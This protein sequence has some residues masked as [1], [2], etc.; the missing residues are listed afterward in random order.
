MFKNKILFFQIRKYSDFKIFK[1]SKM[2][3]IW[4]CSKFEKYSKFEKVH[5]QKLFKIRKYSDFTSKNL[6]KNNYK[7]VHL[8]RKENI[9][10]IE[11][12]K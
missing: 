8:F 9:I 10:A 3:T 5:I 7:N 11:K 1:K 2:F 6:G 12:R 4:K